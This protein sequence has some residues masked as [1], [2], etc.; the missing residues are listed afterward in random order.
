MTTTAEDDR[1]AYIILIVIGIVVIGSVFG[2]YQQWTS[3][4]RNEGDRMQFV[5]GTEYTPDQEGQVAVLILN[6][7]NEPVTN[8]YVCNYTVLYPNKTVFLQDNMTANTS[9]GTQYGEF[10]I[11]AVAGVYEYASTCVNNPRT[12]TAAK[13]FHVSGTEVIFEEEGNDETKLNDWNINAWRFDVDFADIQSANCKIYPI[14]VE[15]GDNYKPVEDELISSCYYVS[16]GVPNLSVNLFASG[17]FGVASTDLN[18][19]FNTSAVLVGN[20][21]NYPSSTLNKAPWD[22]WATSTSTFVGGTGFKGDTSNRLVKYVA[23][24][25]KMT[26]S[27]YLSEDCGLLS[28]GMAETFGNPYVNQ[29]YWYNISVDSPAAGAFGLNTSNELVYCYWT[30]E[31][32]IVKSYT[33]NSA[34][35]GR[36]YAVAAGWSGCNQG[37]FIDA[38]RDWLGVQWYSNSSYFERGNNYGIVCD[39]S[40]YDNVNELKQ[41]YLHQYVYVNYDGKLRAVIAK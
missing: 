8:N 29:G 19:Y 21:L 13:S 38:G 41:T 12:L 20:D 16:G 17:A 28:G 10:T 39:V 2:I 1:S 5:S 36:L 6:Y 34:I 7:Q 3:T 27:E 35:Y 32:Q 30:D 24:M 31:D 26:Y 9:L 40:Y 18:A 37:T 11:P 23:F 33:Y 15:H 22:V 14:I 4:D 25:G